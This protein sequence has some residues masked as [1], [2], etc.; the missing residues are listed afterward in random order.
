LYSSI[1]FISIEL[2]FFRGT[3]GYTLFFSTKG[4]KK[5][6]KQLKVEAVEEE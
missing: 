4:M 3:G 5:L 1:N 6:L 2:K